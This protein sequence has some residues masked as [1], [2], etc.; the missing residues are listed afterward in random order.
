MR[1][2]PA[3]PPYPAPVQRR[4]DAIMPQGMEPLML[5]RVMAR[6]ER[7]FERMMS[8]GLLDRGTLSIRQREI[9]ILRTC[10][11]CGCGY[12]WGVHAA[13]YAPKGK[14]TPAEVQATAPE[15][16][17]DLWPPEEALILEL[18]D[19]LHETA[20]CPDGLWTRLKA[21]FSDEQLVELLALAGYYHQ[22]A[23]IA[24]AARLPRE[25][26]ATELP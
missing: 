8:G 18:A 4:L 1:I 20:T 2:T 3:Q 25:P 10:A 5:F 24:N 7:V 12:E 6:N 9:M 14:L 21:F 26:F 15:A 23:Y 11:R 16:T 22:I 13:V 19:A 17:G